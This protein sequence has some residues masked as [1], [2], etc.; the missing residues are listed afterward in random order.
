MLSGYTITIMGYI[1]ASI[2][3][4]TIVKPLAKEQSLRNRLKDSTSAK[5]I[6]AEHTYHHHKATAIVA[7]KVITTITVAVAIVDRVTS[8]TVVMNCLVY[9]RGPCVEVSLHNLSQ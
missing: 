5:L 8:F 4:A 1:M 6:V 3:A 2:A 7:S 9:R